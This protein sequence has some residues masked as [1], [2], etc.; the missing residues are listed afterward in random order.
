MTIITFIVRRRIN[1]ICDYEKTEKNRISLLPALIFEDLYINYKLNKY[2]ETKSKKMVNINLSYST[3]TCVLIFIIALEFSVIG[4]ILTFITP[5]IA[6]RF[7]EAGMTLSYYTQL[8]MDLSNFL[9][10]NTIYIVLGFAPILIFFKKNIEKVLL[11]GSLVISI[12]CT[13]LLIAFI[14]VQLVEA[15]I[16]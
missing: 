5:Q 16:V 13:L 10:N 8:I 3:I 14:G 9:Q 4:F 1:A 6:S 2:G 11:I 7:S 12:I 15:V